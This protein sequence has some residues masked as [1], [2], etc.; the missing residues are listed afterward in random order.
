MYQLEP[1]GDYWE[2]PFYIK[3]YRNFR[4]KLVVPFHA[5]YSW[6]WYVFH[7]KDKKIDEIDF[8]TCWLLSLAIASARIGT[9]HKIIFDENK[10]GEE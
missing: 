1:I 3:I 7:P 5:I 10:L 2:A 6:L 4:H 9:A 8:R